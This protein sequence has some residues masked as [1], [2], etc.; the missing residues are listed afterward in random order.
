[1]A[2]S[3]SY[4]QKLWVILAITLVLRLFAMWA[5]PLTDTTEARYGEIARKMEETNNWVTPL[6]NYNAPQSECAHIACVPLGEHD[7]GVPFWAKPPLS[8]W[9]AAIS[10]KVFGVNEFAARLP[11]L[12]FCLGIL[13]LI[14]AWL[15][16]RA[17]NLNLI[18]VTVLATSLLFCGSAGLVMTDLALIFCSAFS[19]ICFWQAAVEDKGKRWGYLFFIGMGVGLL[20]KGPLILVLVGLPTGAWTLLHRTFLTVWQRLPWLTG[21]TLTFAIAAPWYWLAEQST[22]GFIQY[23][24]VGEHFSRFLISGWQG[25]LYGHAHSEPLGM[26]W[27]YVLSGFLPWMGL[28]ISLLI[29]RRKETRWRYPLGDTWLSYLILW[30]VMPV[31]FFTFAHNIISPYALPAMPA[32]AILLA[33]FFARFNRTTATHGTGAAV[34]N[35]QSFYR[36]SM[37]TPVL[38]VLAIGIYIALPNSMPKRSEKDIAHV[39]M[40]LRKDSSSQ[41]VYVK[42][43]LYSA[44]FY[45]AG[46]ARV[47]NNVEELQKLLGNSTQDFVAVDA[48][49]FN[50]EWKDFISA[51]FKKVAEFHNTSLFQECETADAC[52]H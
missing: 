18:A 15:T 29:T 3:A 12:L 23:F 50:A 45:T 48:R 17:N 26:I 19:M 1:M 52:Q 47:V 9:T 31:I 41:L 27:L 10:M 13:W 25:D 5:I 44:E 30:T 14:Y 4:K 43:R 33:E 20:A 11:S 37:V 22:P 32:G 40:E 8:T 49:Y 38:F 46:K 6:H 21:F 16:P 2:I 39:Y 35:V 42:D 34:F 36:L 7:F 51:H 24:I 28:V